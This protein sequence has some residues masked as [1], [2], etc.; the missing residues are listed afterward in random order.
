MV[1]RHP[2]DP[3]F[4]SPTGSR[5]LAGA[6]IRG[7]PW[8]GSDADLLELLRA[9]G[10]SA[11]VIL[12]DRFG[13]EIHRVVWHVLG[14]DSEHEDV[15]HQVF[16]NI[17]KGIRSIRSADAL[18][19]WVVS[20][21]IKTTRSEIRRR[22]RFRLFF[23][24]REPREQEALAIVDPEGREL[25]ERTFAILDRLPA[26]ERIAFVLQ[27]L[28]EQPLTEVARLCDCSLA[29]IKRRL[30]RARRRFERLARREPALAERLVAA[31]RR[32]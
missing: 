27:N 24:A 32:S 16:I 6:E 23:G 17:L 2:K 31:G 1:D 11:G 3:P 7:V 5:N 28:E 10:P 25:V 9:Q 19:A 30:A 14:P 21:A 8:K 22:R 12:H 13:K 20:V 18:H 4:E 29:T 15:V 26:N